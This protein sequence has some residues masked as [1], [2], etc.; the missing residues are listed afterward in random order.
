MKF[1]QWF[2]NQKLGKKILY[3]FVVS[4]L[5]PILIVQGMMMYV[6]SHDLKKKMDELMMNQLTQVAE[7]T[8]LTLDIYTNAVYQAYADSQ[9]IGNITK[10]SDATCTDKEVAYREIYS[11]LQQYGTSVEGIQCISLICTDGN[12]ITYDFGYASAVENIWKNYKDLREIEPYK[13]AQKSSGVVIT[14]TMR[15]VNGEKE[16]RTF[17]I[18]KKI[19]DFENIEKGAIAT[20]VMSIDERILNENCST[21]G[22]GNTLE[23]YSVSFI[24]DDSGNVMTYPNAF[25][26]GIPMNPKFSPEEFV[27]ATGKLKK[28]NVSVKEYKD[29]SLGWVFYNVYDKEYMLRD[30]TKTQ[31]F[32]FLIGFMMTVIAVILIVYTVKIIENS[33][34]KIVNGIQ[35][36]QK[37]NLEVKVQVDSGDEVG[38]IAENFNT[39]TEKVQELIVEVTEVTKKQKEAEI[40]TLEAQINPH[41]LYNTLDSINWMAIDKKEYEI[42]T[43]LRNLGVILRYSVNKSNQMVTIE[44]LTDWLNK[45]VSLQ[46]MRFNNSFE[47]RLKVETR[48]KS[49]K[50]YK[51]LLQPF[52]ENSILHGFK[53]IESGGII[54]IDIMLSEDGTGLNLII[55][56]NGSGMEQK[57][58]QKY[59]NQEEAVKDDGRSI[60]LHNAFSRMKMYYGDRVSWNVSSILNVG[61]VITLKIPV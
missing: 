34:K 56:D 24:A 18:S 50:V 8:S 41:F 14:P 6:T 5:I 28:E 61:T 17:H 48:A 20:I 58:V 57:Y 53:G 33:I 60:G 44:E 45:Y 52:V 11:R 7:R 59:N 35:E 19:Y 31:Q 30:V 13:R 25:Y 16:Y 26:S 2:K 49:V 4:S 15:F 51:L 39:M 40:K 12:H 47:F 32:S 38:Q 9:I 29:K 42:S 55:E 36:V 1:L 46:Q 10:L 3:A 21:I 22:K 37:G 27:Q 43:M 54:R 23:E